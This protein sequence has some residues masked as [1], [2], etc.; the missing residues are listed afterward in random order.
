MK[1]KNLSK[2][3]RIAIL[4]TRV[5]DLV[6]PKAPRYE[7]NAYRD[8][9]YL[10]CPIIAVIVVTYFL[11]SNNHTDFCAALLLHR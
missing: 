3:E 9:C 5:S 6:K 1:R 4:E 10:L 11:K 7:N 2:E 8:L